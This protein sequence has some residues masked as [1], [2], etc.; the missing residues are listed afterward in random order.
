MIKIHN[1]ANVPRKI[2]VRGEKM[3]KSKSFILLFCLIFLG[4]FH[5]CFSKEWKRVYLASYPRSGNHWVRYLVEEA[6]HIATGSVYLDKEPLHMDKVFPWGGYCC[7][8]GCEGNCRYPTK[9]DLVFIKTHFP[10]Q[11]DKVTQYDRRPYE[12]TIRIVRHPVD[13]FY[14]R[15]VKRSGGELLDK[16]PTQRVKEFIRTWIKFQNYWNK[17]ENVITIRYEDILENPAGELK[18]ILETLEYDVTDEDIARA[19]AT[20]PPQGHMLK[21]IGHFTS[22]DLQLIAKELKDSLVQFGYEIPFNQE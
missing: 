11:P 19:V 9:D 7:E 16:V 14:S 12:A 10:S 13:S 17:Q 1:L 2:F 4:D 22:S 21:S 6:S 3:L 8:H 15:Y 20:H 18:K 5:S